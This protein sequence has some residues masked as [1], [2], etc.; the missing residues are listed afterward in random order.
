[1]P[2][3]SIVKA[4]LLSL[5]LLISVFSMPTMAVQSSY[6]GTSDWALEKQDQG[7]TIFSRSIE[8][9]TFKEFKATVTIDTTIDAIVAVFQDPNA[10]TQWVHQCS[11]AEVIKQPSFLEIYVYQIS[12][13]PLLVSDRD[14]V[15][16][17]VFNYSK[18][19]KTWT[20]N[21]STADHLVP[22][23]D[24]VRIT[25]SR[26]TYQLQE[27]DEGQVDLTWYQ[28][29]DPGGALPSWLVNSLIVDLPFHTLNN[30]RELS[31]QEKYRNSKIG[32]NAQGIPDHWAEKHF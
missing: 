13:M 32:Y 23:T 31:T 30:L 12:D 9:S 5:T 20:I 1:M 10:F 15:I 28:H 14:I 25:E 27:N 26:G 3:H 21:V 2:S 6:K 29:A 11:H 8:G 4:V 7:I 24:N 18:D 17:D 16:K 19:Y 22:V